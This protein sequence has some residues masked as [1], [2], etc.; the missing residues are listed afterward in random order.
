MFLTMAM[1]GH[2]QVPAQ[3]GTNLQTTLP[4]HF[5]KCMQNHLAEVPH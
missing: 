3:A 2:Q 5:F 4:C 1:Q